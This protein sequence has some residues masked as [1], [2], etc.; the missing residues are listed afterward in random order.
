MY[1]DDKN[2]QYT[3]KIG[4]IG[5]PKTGLNKNLDFLPG[6]HAVNSVRKTAVLRTWHILQKVLQS[7]T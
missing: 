6:K 5:I 1:R 3:G 2:V 7:E 4:A